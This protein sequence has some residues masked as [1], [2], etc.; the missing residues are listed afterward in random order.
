MGHILKL[1]E[2][3]WRAFLKSLKNQSPRLKYVEISTE[4]LFKAI[5]WLQP[6]QKCFC[7]AQI[8]LKLF[9]GVLTSQ[10]DPKTYL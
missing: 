5:E 10:N 2:A 9:G 4:A 6:S 1:F 8:V 7:V 3:F